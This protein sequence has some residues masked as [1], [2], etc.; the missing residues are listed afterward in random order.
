VA[1]T[2]SDRLGLR[3]TDGALPENAGRRRAIQAE[4]ERTIAYYD[5]MARQREEREERERAM[6]GG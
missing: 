5:A 2:P 1:N 6:R 4:N 3:G